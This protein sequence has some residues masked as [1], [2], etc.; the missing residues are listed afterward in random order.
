VDRLNQPTGCEVLQEIKSGVLVFR[1]A[2]FLPA[3]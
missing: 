3:E 1:I 2:L